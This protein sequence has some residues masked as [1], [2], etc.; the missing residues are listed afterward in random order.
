MW[1]RK[2]VRY[3]DNVYETVLVPNFLD[4]NYDWAINETV[5]LDML[6]CRN[7]QRIYNR[8][9]GIP[10]Y[11]AKTGLERDIEWTRQIEIKSK[12][13]LKKCSVSMLVPNRFLA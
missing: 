8:T 2:K 5:Y 10:V 9:G 11:C 6:S 3:S 4:A 12:L 13:S 7:C 1:V